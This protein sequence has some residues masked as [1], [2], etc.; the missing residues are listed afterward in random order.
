ML[1]DSLRLRPTLQENTGEK[2]EVMEDK[3]WL[4]VKVEKKGFTFN[5]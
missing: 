4:K 5:F 2:P 3:H 1:M